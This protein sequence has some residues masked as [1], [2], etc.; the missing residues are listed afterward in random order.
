M[1]DDELWNAFHDRTLPA[2]DWTHRAHLRVAWM[3]VGRYPLDEAHLLFR[4]AL[5]RLNTVHE[6]PESA[7]R[8]YHETLTRV[9][10][11]LVSALR[12]DDA[13][14][15]AFLE[16]CLAELHRDAPL[17]YYTRELLYSV[18]ARS[19]FVPPDREPL[20]VPSLT[21]R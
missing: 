3:F 7:Q 15:E 21:A 8:G 11:H 20:P 1:T 16:R 13:T 19:V 4:V 2:V 14:S 5:I 6:V 12:S 17:R 18:H 9:W 10:L